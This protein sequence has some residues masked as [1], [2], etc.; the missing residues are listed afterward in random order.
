ME[1]QSMK[2]S[3]QYLFF[4]ISRDHGV[5]CRCSDDGTLSFVGVGTKIGPNKKG[6]LPVMTTRDIAV[7]IIT[8]CPKRIRHV[9][10]PTFNCQIAEDAYSYIKKFMHASDL[11]T[12]AALNPYTQLGRKR[13]LAEFELFVNDEL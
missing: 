2:S 7:D 1:S 8:K 5:T 10:K 11:F 12:R 4:V 13:L 9:E 6:E 3:N